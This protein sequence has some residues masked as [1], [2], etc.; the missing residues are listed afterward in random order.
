MTLGFKPAKG[1]PEN[2]AMV[3]EKLLK[4]YF[5][6]TLGITEDPPP[7]GKQRVGF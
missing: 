5:R 7:E 4:P 2:A 6:W 3:A 1:D